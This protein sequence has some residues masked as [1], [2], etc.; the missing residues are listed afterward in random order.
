[1]HYII[2]YIKYCTIL[3]DIVLY[4]VLY[5]I[6]YSIIY[7]FVYCIFYYILY[8]IL[9]YIILY[10]VFFINTIYPITII[11]T[12]TQSLRIIICTVITYTVT[13]VTICMVITYTIISFSN[14]IKYAKI[15]YFSLDSHLLSTLEIYKQKKS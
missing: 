4:V 9:Y 11:V 5:H 13:K 14:E 6:L 1:M 12:Y 15:H 10:C 2:Y 8:C 3:Y 7:H